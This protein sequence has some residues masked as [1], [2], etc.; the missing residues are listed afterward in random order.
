MYALHPHSIYVQWESSMFC[1][2]YICYAHCIV[3]CSRGNEGKTWKRT[4]FIRGKQQTIPLNV[5]SC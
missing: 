5:C 4:S 2:P 1:S 3:V